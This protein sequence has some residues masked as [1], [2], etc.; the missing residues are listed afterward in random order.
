MTLSVHNCT[1]RQRRDGHE[2]WIFPCWEFQHWYAVGLPMDLGI[3]SN[4]FN[5]EDPTWLWALMH[6]DLPTYSRL[7][8]VLH[9]KF[10]SWCDWQSH[11]HHAVPCGFQWQRYWL[12][13][14]A[15]QPDSKLIDRCHIKRCTVNFLVQNKMQTTVSLT[16]VTW[17]LTWSQFEFKMKLWLY[18]YKISSECKWCKLGKWSEVFMM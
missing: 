16:W 7:H 18:M 4:V 2:C 14:S 3:K 17:I 8:F 12:P 5:F 1:M 15:H 13:R 11:S 10:H 6:Y 9:N